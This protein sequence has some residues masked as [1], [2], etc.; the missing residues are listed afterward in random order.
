MDFWGIERITPEQ[1]E[2][3]ILEN[4]KSAEFREELTK[5]VLTKAFN[6]FYNVNKNDIA[7]PT[8]IE[9]IKSVKS[10]NKEKGQY[11]L[12]EESRFGEWYAGIDADGELQTNIGISDKSKWKELDLVWVGLNSVVG[13]KKDG[14][15]IQE[16]SDPKL[17][18]Y[19]GVKAVVTSTYL[20]ETHW[21]VQ[22]AD[23][24]W[25]KDGGEPREQGYELDK[26]TG[27]ITDAE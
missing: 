7:H 23:N 18:N 19:R 25:I 27:R 13:L 22:T 9:L 3:V 20:G 15:L 8:V 10:A 24:M 5:T 6:T 14:S 2:D 16:G 4:Q 21:A 12:T 26:D 17:C 11:L 1:F